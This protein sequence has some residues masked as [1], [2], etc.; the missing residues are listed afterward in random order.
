[1]AD[2]WGLSLDQPPARV[3][4]VLEAA[5]ASGWQ[6]GPTGTTLVARLYRPDHEGLPFFAR[7]DL[8]STGEGK[9][10][11][12]FHGA[13]AANGQRLNYRDIFTYLDD[14][15]VIYPEDPDANRPAAA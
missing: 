4:K 6:L 3:L 12:R 13:M 15:S 5:E 10:S 7:W 2:P 11:W 9:R 14:P 1:M 8:V